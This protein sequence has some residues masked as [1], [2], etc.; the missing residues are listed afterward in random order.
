[1]LRAILTPNAAMEAG[2]RNFRIELRDGEVLDGFLVKEEDNAF[3][4]RQ[5][6]L[7]DQRI[8]KDRAR[9]FDFTQKSLMPEGLLDSLQPNEVSD[10]FAYLKSLK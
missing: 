6:N 2:Y 10:L 4:L 1:M 3:V 9:R 7:Q 8:E 5:P